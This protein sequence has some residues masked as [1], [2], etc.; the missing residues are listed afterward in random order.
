MFDWGVQCVEAIDH[1]KEPGG[2]EGW[3]LRSVK[4]KA[5]GPT[6]RQENTFENS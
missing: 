1:V 5:S 3:K 4:R 2:W 6:I